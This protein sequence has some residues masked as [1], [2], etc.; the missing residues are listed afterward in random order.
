MDSSAKLD[1]QK[2]ISFIEYIFCEIKVI[3][4]DKNIYDLVRLSL[5]H[6]Y[7]KEKVS[8]YLTQKYNL[9]NK[10]QYFRKI[11]EDKL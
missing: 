6:N 11:N 4:K 3:K 7:T 10:Y 8:A 5:A 1:V 2:H 9:V